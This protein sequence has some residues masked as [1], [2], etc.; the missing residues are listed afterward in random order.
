MGWSTELFCNISFNRKSYNSLSEVGD[1]IETAKKI[2]QLY[3]DKIRAYAV[4]TEPDKMVKF[5]DERYDNLLMQIDGEVSDMLE[6]MEEYYDELFRLQYLWENWEHCHTKDGLAINA[7]KEITW[8]TAY[9]DG[10][11]VKSANNPSNQGDLLN[12]DNKE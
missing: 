2:I 7:P 11:F 12:M 6:E 1:D 4:M 3:K 9:L 5:D 8:E 10:D